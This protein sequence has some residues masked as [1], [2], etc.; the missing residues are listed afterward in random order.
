MKNGEL[1]VTHKEVARRCGIPSSTIRRLVSSGVW[2]SPVAW[3]ERTWFYR[4]A[5]VQRFIKTGE[6]PNSRIV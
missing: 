2:P 4:A 6:W 3:T 1:L 5:D